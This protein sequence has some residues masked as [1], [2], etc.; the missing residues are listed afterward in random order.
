MIRSSIFENAQTTRTW[1]V[2]TLVRLLAIFCHLSEVNLNTYN[3]H[4]TS[5]Q[6]KTWSI[7]SRP[8]LGVES[9]WAV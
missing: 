4:H 9:V 6:L 2:V 8:V 3:A 1:C 5:D 7:F